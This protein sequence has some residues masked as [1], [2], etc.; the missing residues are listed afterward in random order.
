M[1]NHIYFEIDMLAKELGLSE[2][3]Y[4]EIKHSIRGEF[5]DDELMYQLH[6]VRAL[7]ALTRRATFSRKE[8]KS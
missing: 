7:H 8:G 6:I 5:P 3:K 1:T 2:Q 4:N